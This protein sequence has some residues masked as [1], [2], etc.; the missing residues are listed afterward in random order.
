MFQHLKLPE[1]VCLKKL[2]NRIAQRA[3]AETTGII[4]HVHD[5]KPASGMRP[6]GN[7]R[8]GDYRSIFMIRFRMRFAA[9]CS[10]PSVS[11]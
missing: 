4:L 8:D 7:I 1:N 9:A 10:S 2:R 6:A 3:S 11:G 5:E